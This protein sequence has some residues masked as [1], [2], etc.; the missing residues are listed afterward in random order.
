[1]F[2]GSKFSTRYV[3]GVLY[4]FWMQFCNVIFQCIFI[5]KKKKKKTNC[6]D[7]CA[8]KISI[9]LTFTSSIVKHLSFYTSCLRSLK[10]STYIYLNSISS[11]E[12]F[13]FNYVLLPFKST[14]RFQACLHIVCTLA[15]LCSSPLKKGNPKRKR[16]N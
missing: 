9:E 2:Y 1:M 15:E 10:V 14:H 12:A 4:L 6:K 8:N 5:S 13:C 3:N 11:T 7:N 16:G